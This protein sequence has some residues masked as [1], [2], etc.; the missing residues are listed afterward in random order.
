MLLHEPPCAGQHEWKSISDPEGGVRGRHICCKPASSL[1]PKISKI[2]VDK[3]LSGTLIS[4]IN[5]DLIKEFQHKVQM[6]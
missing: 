2:V 4:F 1:S 5:H 3:W 6:V